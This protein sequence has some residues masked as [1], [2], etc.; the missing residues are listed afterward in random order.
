MRWP[1]AWR[2][3]AE[4]LLVEEYNNHYKGRF[5]PDSDD[6]LELG[7]VPGTT[8]PTS[9]PASSHG[10]DADADEEGWIDEPT[11]DGAQDDDM[12]LV[13]PPP[14]LLACTA[15]DSDSFTDVSI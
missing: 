7:S 13:R 15:T 1:E 4:D 14:A 6:E 12:D 10:S 9:R 11:G 2:Q 3:Q 5:N 8:P